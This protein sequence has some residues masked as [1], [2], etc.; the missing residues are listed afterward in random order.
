MSRRSDPAPRRR[1][2]LPA[3][4]Q[5]PEW[6]EW[7]REL[8]RRQRRL[9][10]FVGLSQEQLARRAGISQ[11]A[12]SRLEGA[13]GLAIPMLIVFKTNAALVRELRR[14]DPTGAGPEL[15]EALGLQDAL[16]PASGALAGGEP[17]L[18]EDAQLA[19]LIGLYHDTPTRYRQGLLALMRTMVM[20][21]KVLPLAIAALL[22]G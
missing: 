8:G 13:R 19:D 17:A 18:V 2:P 4:A 10:E 7:M 12:V 3:S 15:R 21:L 22:G 5:E 20:G 16:M 11:G 14:L 9:R 6:R 1:L